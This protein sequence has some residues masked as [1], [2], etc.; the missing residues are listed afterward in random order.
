[1]IDLQS[2]REEKPLGAEDLQKIVSLLKIS[3]QLVE[4]ELRGMSM[5]KTLPAG[6]R[7]RICSNRGEDYAAGEIVTFVANRN[8]TA[9]RVVYRGQGS[10]KKYLITRGDA[11]LLCDPPVHV[12]QVLGV[13]TEFQ[14]DGDW[15]VPVAT[16]SEPFLGRCLAAFMLFIMSTMLQ[17]NV[18]WAT[19]LG[20]GLIRLKFALFRFL[21]WVRGPRTAEP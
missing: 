5:G 2:A 1:M 12:E 19:G 16:I 20:R 8:L 10:K 9:H 18:S 4:C 21:S 13:V 17:L 11:N 14:T 7:V 3:R 6:S 15:K